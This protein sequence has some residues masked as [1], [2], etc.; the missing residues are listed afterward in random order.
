M[1]ATLDDTH[2]KEYETLVYC[3]QFM[4]ARPNEGLSLC[5]QFAY[6]AIATGICAQPELESR[7]TFGRT[8]VSAFVAK[9]AGSSTTTAERKGL[10]MPSMS[11]VGI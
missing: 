11:F 6:H 9:S 8:A 4:L 7:A 1:V 3:V 10:Y 2:R 5:S